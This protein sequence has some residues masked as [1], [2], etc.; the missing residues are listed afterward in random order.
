MPRTN[1][2][3]GAALRAIRERSNLSVRDVVAELAALGIDAHEDHLRNV[4]TGRRNAGRA[5]ATGL[6]RVLRVPSTAI[7]AAPTSATTAQTGVR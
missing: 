4:E 2:T 5:L 6:A 3:N 1:P 7:L